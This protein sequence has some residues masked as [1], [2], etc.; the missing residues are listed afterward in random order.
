MTLVHAQMEKKKHNLRFAKNDDGLQ[1]PIQ[2]S[3]NDLMTN[4]LGSNML[5]TQQDSDIASSGSKVD[6]GGHRPLR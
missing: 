2:F 6:C 1:I 5:E 3:N 4:M